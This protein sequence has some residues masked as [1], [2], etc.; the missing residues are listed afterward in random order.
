M[1]VGFWKPERTV[2]S[3][4]GICNRSKERMG[5][6]GGPFFAVVSVTELDCIYSSISEAVGSE[7]VVE[8]EVELEDSTTVDSVS[9]PR[10]SVFLRFFFSFLEELSSKASSRFLRFFLRSGSSEAETMDEFHISE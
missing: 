5:L 7:V 6:I 1:G 8:V 4:G 3:S 2:L 10:S 9:G